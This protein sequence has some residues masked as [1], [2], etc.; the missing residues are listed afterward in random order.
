[1]RTKRLC[2]SGG[3][4]PA[5]LLAVLLTEVAG[6]S[7]PTP[8]MCVFGHKIPDTDA[9][10]SAL[11]YEWELGERGIPAQAYRLGELNRETEYVLEALGVEAP[12]L[13]E[14]LEEKAT[15]AIVD[16]NNPAELPDGLDK[17]TVHSIVD[18]HKLCGLMTCAPLEVDI[19]PRTRLAGPQ[20]CSPALRSARRFVT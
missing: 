13:L 17:A 11:I 14:R 4:L 12:P 6:G 15:V 8:K 19:R 9:I 2:R 16:T 3:M 7:A 10:C 1:M 5:S 20:P 18:H